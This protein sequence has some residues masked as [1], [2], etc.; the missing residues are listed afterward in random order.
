MIPEDIQ[1]YVE[2]MRNNEN[3]F[4]MS[5][6]GCGKSF[7]LKK[8]YYFVTQANMFRC[9]LTSSTGISA[10]N[11]GGVTVHHWAGVGIAQA[12]VDTLVSRIESNLKAYRKWTETDYLF[13]DEVSM[14]SGELIDKFDAIGRIIREKPDLPFGGIKLFLSG[15][16][17]QLPSPKG[18][19][20]FNSK[21]WEELDLMVI[22][23]F[24]PYR[25]PDMKWFKML[26]RI[27]VGKHTKKDIKKLK[28]RVVS[29]STL[30][31]L[32]VP[33]LYPL[34]RNVDIENTTRLDKL[35]SNYVSFQCS[36]KMKSKG[37]RNSGSDIIIN[38][39]RN[40]YK[41]YT[42][43]MDTNVPQIVNLKEGAECLLTYN[44]NLELGLANGTRCVIESIVEPMSGLVATGG[45][46]VRVKNIAD[47]VHV[48]Y[49]VFEIE[50]ECLIYKR[51]QIPLKIAYAI[52]I[53]KVQGMTL[54]SLCTN[55][56]SGI[57]CAGQTYVA[58]SRCKT[59]DNLYLLD[60][61]ERKIIV[62]PDALEYEKY[63]QSVLD[64]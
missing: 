16:C 51:Y 20:F 11:I 57:F 41:S 18:G 26:M 31:E 6:G 21:V 23:N 44:L 56:N 30:A 15:D 38:F 17:M 49:V 14:L 39:D 48:P 28:Q 5:P 8:V 61:D 22:R 34:N 12:D 53:H 24:T 60:F 54:D 47:P 3:I 62:D 64:E 58:L 1:E 37:L 43:M 36:D 63:V 9:A 35:E 55:I 33:L 7:I 25:Y 59:L 46:I 2:C 29:R 42:D 32:N 19:W 4:L 13:L 40:N 45:V 27:R 10:V 50:D 52:T